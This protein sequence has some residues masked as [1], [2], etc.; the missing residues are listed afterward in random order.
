MELEIISKYPGKNNRPTPI[1]FVH[2]AFAGAWCWE[3][4]F[5][6]YFAAHGYEAHALSLRGHGKSE[7]LENIRVHSFPDYLYDVSQVILSLKTCPILVGHSMGGFIIQKYLE[8]CKIHAC[9]LMGSVPPGGLFFPSMRMLWRY[10]ELCRKIYL[11]NMLPKNMWQYVASFEEIRDL[12]FNKAVTVETVKKYLP[13]FQHESYRIM[14]EMTGEYFLA[15]TRKNTTPMLVLGAENDIFIPPVFV[16]S[17][18]KAYNTQAHI[19]PGMGHAMMLDKDWQAAA[20][21]I[22]GWLNE[23]GL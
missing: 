3:E 20:D 15:D 5:L 12:F 14:W 9:V 4:Y 22:L 18:A 16:H 10:P 23:K 8:S 7:G 13:L 6:P 1:L 2:G 19:F 21:R 17:T 11:I